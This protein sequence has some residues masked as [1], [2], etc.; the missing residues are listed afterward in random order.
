MDLPELPTK[1]SNFIP[2]LDSQANSGVP[3]SQALEPFKYYEAKLRQIFAQEPGHP[4]SQDNHVNL[5]PLFAGHE[6]QLNIRARQLNRESQA[7]KEKYILSLNDQHRKPNGSP[8]TVQTLKQFENN[9]KLFS[10]SSLADLDWTNVVAAGSSVITPLLPIPEEHNRTKRAQRD[11]YHEQ[12]APASDVD[13]FLY[14]LNEEQAIKKIKQIEACV[15]GSI[16][17]E[18]TSIR[19][20]NTITIVSKYPIR[21][22]QV[23]LRLYKSVSEILTGF[24]VDCSCFAYDGSQVWATPRAVAAVVTQTNTIDLTRRSPSYE[25]R[26]AKYAHRGFEVYWSDLDRSK[27]DPTIFERSF[28]HVAG[29]A[30]LL[31]MEQLPLQSERDDYLA[32]R[33]AERGRAQVFTKGFRRHAPSLKERQPEDVAEWADEEDVSDYHSITIPYGP[34]YNAKRIEKLLYKKDLLLNAEWNK[35][36][37]RKVDLHRH[38]AFF[39]AVEDIIQDCCGFCPSPMTEED[40]EVAEIENKRFISG[41]VQFMK[42]NPG[43]QAIGSFNPITDDGW[44]EMAYVSNMTR[45]CQAIVD[46]DLGYVE[47]WCSRDG[48]CVDSRD[49][50][51]RTPL[52]LAAICG[53]VAIV[54]CLIN[55]GARLA[56][57]IGG[58][59]TALHIAAYKG[60]DEI[61]KALLEKSEEN[62]AKHNELLNTQKE[63]DK[64]ASRGEPNTTEKNGDL[65]DYSVVSS[66]HDMQCATTEA[67]FV[68]ITPPQPSNDLIAE[69]T[70]SDQPNVYSVN[71]VAWEEPV[72][73]LHLA[74]MYGH[75]KVVET[76]ASTFGAD[77][78]LPVPMKS[79]QYDNTINTL[80]TLSL[81]L[82]LPLESCRAVIKSLLELGASSAQAN[83]NQVTAFHAAIVKGSPELLDVLFE[84]DSAAAQSAVNHPS[85]SESSYSPKIH[86]PISSAIAA[87]NENMVEKLLAQGAEASKSVES[88]QHLVAE[89]FKIHEDTYFSWDAAR[90]S[91][92]ILVATI[93][94]KPEI[95]KLMLDHGADPNTLTHDGRN[96]VLHSQKPSQ[97][98][99]G[100]SLLDIVNTRL[101]ALKREFPELQPDDHY[102]NGL[103]Q[104]SYKYWHVRNK[105]Q[106][107]RLARDAIRDQLKVK[108]SGNT[109]LKDGEEN[110]LIDKL[111]KDLEAVRDILKEKGAKTFAELHPTLALVPPHDEPFSFEIGFKFSS[112]YQSETARDG[113]LRLFQAAWEN[114]V[115]TIKSLT[116]APWDPSEHVPL[117]VAVWD[118]NSFTPFSIAIY[119]GHVETAK[120][121]LEIADAQYKPT[122]QMKRV[123]ADIDDSDVSDDDSSMYDTDP[124]EYED[125]GTFDIR[126]IEKL[127]PSNVSPLRVLRKSA[128]F[129]K[130]QEGAESTAKAVLAGIYVYER[131][132]FSVSP[133]LLDMTVGPLSMEPS[134]TSLRYALEIRDPKLVAMIINQGTRYS[135]NNEKEPAQFSISVAELDTALLWGDKDVLTVLLAKTGAGLPLDAL[136]KQSGVQTE[137]KSKFYQGLSVYGKKRTDWAAADGA[138]Y[139]SSTLDIG[140]TPLLRAAI[141]ANIDSVRWFLSDG[142]MEA[143]MKFASSNKRDPRLKALRNAA[144]G[145]EKT[146]SS[147]LNARRNLALSCAIMAVP[148]EE[149]SVEY[150]RLL[151]EILPASLDYKDAG[152]MTPLHFALS[153]RQLSAAEFLVKS[154]A[155]QA[156]RDNQC[157]NILHHL[158]VSHKGKPITSSKVFEAM[159][160]LVDPKLARSLA[161]EKA[162]IHWSTDTPRQVT[163]LAHWLDTVDDTVSPNVLRTILQYMDGRALTSMNSQGDYPIHTAIK[164]EQ[165]ELAKVLIEH[166]PEFLVCE[167]ATGVTALDILDDKYRRYCLDYGTRM[168]DLINRCTEFRPNSFHN[169]SSLTKSEVTAAWEEFRAMAAALP[170]KRKLVSL[171]DA[172]ELVRRLEVRRELK[173]TQN[174]NKTA[175]TNDAESQNKREIDRWYHAAL[176]AKN[177]EVEALVRGEKE[178]GTA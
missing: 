31:V 66:D 106:M 1:L 120:L 159:W 112:H 102:L 165:F 174:P 138:S 105:L 146:L 169:T 113:Y 74:A 44:T 145:L 7:E 86:L 153:L 41:K 50:T 10:E 75:W 85:I 87:C 161:T 6:G 60:H 134:V 149:P 56:A 82:S 58:G 24:D 54:K 77:V 95:V 2:Y 109:K 88:F 42:D 141:C 22:V 144:G 152:G 157:R 107:A 90:Y 121:I 127:V 137:K 55:H 115:E 11:Y 79:E 9:F 37:E 131:K 147:W 156:L 25:N 135:A 51:G 103:K 19:T 163:P 21:H 154:G 65:D 61:V 34:K 160:K 52:H 151:L 17:E 92:P 46:G 63:S 117:H 129:W 170:A 148:T 26:L 69:D 126:E 171:L 143:Y 4:A 5:L 178:E 99:R 39:G 155:N 139:V 122:P 28:S 172:N 158:L 118:E 35:S 119:R 36:K 72:S 114:D 176:D 70:D 45:L 108:I 110:K 128:P 32:I 48:V 167:N 91:D 83:T 168:N 68:K 175:E 166:N 27:I 142:P 38:P 49:H 97:W 104:D 116:L 47:K 71:A 62:E 13:L 164:R 177:Y 40:Q 101:E 80:L 3:V 150:L 53:N 130:F 81:C 125:A 140:D 16:L 20:K 133:A 30:R 73:P 98:N 132:S 33:R 15:Q 64:E 162:T 89:R 29:L 59:F 78:L 100:D 67:S 173:R 57:R 18:T 23:V 12:L 124:E 94:N 96:L 8:A 123:H 76:L 14:G 43:R 111:H 136:V 84:Y 93:C